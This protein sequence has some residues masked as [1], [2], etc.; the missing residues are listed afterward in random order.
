MFLEDEKGGNA[1]GVAELSAGGWKRFRSLPR[2]A[3]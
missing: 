1:G 3:T 2:L